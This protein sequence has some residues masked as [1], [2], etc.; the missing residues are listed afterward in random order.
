MTKETPSSPPSVA[1]AEQYLAEALQSVSEGFALYDAEDRLVLCN[2][3]YREIYSDSAEILV[4]G[5]RFEDIIRF[6]ARRNQYRKAQFDLEAFVRERLEQ[7]RNP[8]GPIEQELGDGRWLLIEERRTSMGGIV[9]IRTDITELKRREKRLAEAEALLRGVTDTALDAVVII[10]TAGNFIEFNPA[11]ERLFGFR[12]EE[13]LGRS[14]ATL[15]IPETYRDAH[16]R[17]IR[18]YLATGKS[19]VLGQRLSLEAQNASGQV[20]PVELAVTAIELAGTR[21]FTAT[22]RDIS[23]RV[24]L[25]QALRDARDAAE[26]ASEAKSRFLAVMSHEIRTPLNGVMGALNLLGHTPDPAQHQSLVDAAESSGRA[27]LDLLND[28]LDLSR[29]EA[30]RLLLDEA[31][32]SVADL[33]EE[34]VNIWRPAAS[35]KGLRFAVD[36]EPEMPTRLM[37][38]AGRL[39]Q[40]LLNLVSNAVKFVE[41]GSIRVG[42][43][44]ADPGVR[45]SVE[46]EGPGISE[47]KL[48]ALFQP[49]SQVD[50]GDEGSGLG[51][52]IVKSFAER[53]GGAVGAEN[54]DTVGS[55][56]WFSVPLAAADGEEIRP[57]EDGRSTEEG[58]QILKTASGAPPRVLVA[59][60]APINVK[61]ARLMLERLGCVVDGAANGL[62]A[63]AAVRDR[64]YDLV[65]MDIV[66]P[67]LGGLQATER[68]RALDPPIGTT[69]IIAVTANA[70]PEDVDQY[71]SAGMQACVTKPIT[72]ES[73][74]TA[75]K[76]VLKNA[77]ETASPAGVPQKTANSLPI[78]DQATIDT[79]AKE[80]SAKALQEILEAFAE[81][82]HD[83]GP[84]LSE[85]VDA[86]DAEEVG[87]LA[88]RLVSS[89]QAFGAPSLAVIARKVERAGRSG[90]PETLA[91][92]KELQS[93]LEE[94]RSAFQEF[95]AKA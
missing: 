35:G 37:G 74:S 90:S 95:A 94:T 7:H 61:L 85:A 83:Q 87:R 23:E 76:D 21:Y 12:R 65:L 92:A 41:G 81:E 5:T 56:F 9:G 2:D 77:R 24:A 34:V 19:K 40:M 51:L 71:L 38:D 70:F 48:A 93:C 42:I 31:P 78:R 55:R 18:R 63:V 72:L 60:D 82:L 68:I 15:I 80:I 33:V 43:E 86:G 58:A 73:I 49:F 26:T 75:V 66:M 14:M 67:E 53:M 91:L 4:P 27:L 20:F 79:L 52:A 29:A 10:D 17:G 46:D 44:R 64:P 1:L 3:K 36:L 32:F 62:E 25:E 39:R 13:V 84:L 16:N 89:S 8:A 22:L 6:G 59:D 69:P 28:I 57:S 47:D 50:V 88:H 45:F 54:R 30:D 11:A